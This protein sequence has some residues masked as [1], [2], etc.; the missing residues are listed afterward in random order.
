M[1]LRVWLPLT[2]DLRNQGLDD[3][4]VSGGTIDNNGK[5][6]KCYLVSKTSPIVITQSISTTSEWTINFWARLPSSMNNATA[7]EVMFSFPTINADTGAN[8][9]SNIN[10]ASYHNIKIWDDTNHQWF[11]A[12][13]GTHFN[14]DKWHMWTIAHTANGSGVT[15]K[16]YIDGNLIDTYNNATHQMKIRSGSITIGSGISTGGFYINDFRL[17]DHCLSPMEVKEISKG[18]I[19]HYP[20]NRN[21]WGNDNI[22]INTHFDSRYTQSTGWDT[23]KNGTQLASSWGGYNGGV[24]NP[25][26]VYHAHLKE[27]N[28][29]WVYEYIKTASETWLGI[30]QGGLNSKLIAGKTYTFSWEQYCVSGSNYVQTGLYYFKTG[31]TSA[32]FHLGLIYGNVG[33]ELGKWQKFSRTFIAPEDGDYSKNMSW[34]I[35]GA[36]GNGIV[37]VRH[38]KLEEGNTATPW[39]PS[40]LDTLATTLGINDNIEYDCS[41]FG[42][43]G[44]RTGTFS[45]TNNTP[46]YNVST[47]FNG[48]DNAIQTPSLPSMISDKN[49]TIAVWI[50]KTVI[51]SKSY[52]TIYGGPNGFEI[53]ARNGGANETKFVPWNWGKP[54]ASYELNEWNHCVFVHSDSDCKIYLNGEYIAT[55]T[56]KAANPSG[57]YFVGAWNTAT[58]QNFDGLMSDFRIYATA[59]SAEDVKDLYELG[60]TIDTNGVLSTYE[61]TEQ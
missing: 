61:F 17:Y 31:A 23:T 40:P 34:Y 4:T 33:R 9:T 46:K 13:P 26:T 5:L 14:Y 18:L 15:G 59:L 25:S 27:L 21:G 7:W 43:N 1:S 36:S 22:L 49:Y 52:Q 58:Q 28:G 35:Y 45:W 30:S 51:G 41:G 19:L 12:A 57:N 55:G 60:A 50:Y 32:N 29:E 20:L 47:V 10:W 3:V 42:N 56:A 2:K 16:I 8:G 11:W 53:E 54:M 39:S 38:P 37:Y 48:T 44:T 6:G 24:S